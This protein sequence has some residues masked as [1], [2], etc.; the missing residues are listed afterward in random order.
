[1]IRTANLTLSVS[2]NAGGLF[3]SVRRL[4]QSL[5]QSGMDVR[6]FGVR[7][8]FTDTDISAW[9][10]APVLA[11]PPTWPERFG[12]SPR[13]L[14]ELIAFQP[15]ITHSHGIWVYPSIATNRFSRNTGTPYLISA[16]GMLDRWAVRNSR[17]KKTVAY[18]LYEGT[19]LR[20]A[21]CLRAL[22][23]AEA[24]A[25]RE[26]GLK[27]DIAIIPNGIDLP[28]RGNGKLE[29]LNPPWHN[30]IEPGR[31]VL[32]YLGR[33]HPKKGLVNFLRAWKSTRDARPS[34]CNSW[35][36]AIAGWDQGGHENGLK[37]LADKLG[38]PFSDIRTPNSEIQTSNS[39]L[40]L[41]PQFAE[42]KAACY[43]HCDAFVLPSFS[44][45]VPMVVLEAWADAKPVLM[46]PQCNL[47]EGFS[48]GAALKMEPTIE[49]E[50]NGLNALLQMT[51]HERAA[52]GNCGFAL[53]TKRF[54]WPRIAEQM[55]DLYEWMLGGGT[56]PGCLTDF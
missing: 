29:S 11:F 7:D 42:A 35:V 30:F 3:E 21:R 52:M 56:R 49:S 1:M 40:F 41:G 16:H 8:E 10:P 55:K 19:H 28:V 17:W 6:V 45:G 24:R 27:N 13:F 36:L 14:D 37:S 32:L 22:C 44:E 50:I 46:T 25:I 53:A 33:L 12:Y 9:H 39:V 47:P 5:M 15:D 26:L 2:R 23:E 4:V 31:K 48:T 20:G 54:A 34:A 43:R 51:D 18:F 38:L